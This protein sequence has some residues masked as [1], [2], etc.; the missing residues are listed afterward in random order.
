MRMRLGE[1]MRHHETCMEH[2]EACIEE[3]NQ[4]WGKI[5]QGELCMGQQLGRG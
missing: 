3:K 4:A 2:N 5:R 1:Y